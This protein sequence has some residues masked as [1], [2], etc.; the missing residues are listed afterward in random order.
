MAA[1][2]VPIQSLAPHPTAM[3]H[4]LL[5]TPG[6]PEK[7]AGTF[8]VLPD[9]FRKVIRSLPKDLHMPLGRAKM[10]AVLKNVQRGNLMKKTLSL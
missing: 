9:C 2:W 3:K 1:L 10:G 8:S 7:R 5:V 4:P 6:L